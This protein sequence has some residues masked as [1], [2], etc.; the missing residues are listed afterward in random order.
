[1]MCSNYRYQTSDVRVRKIT[2]VIDVTNYNIDADPTSSTFSSFANNAYRQQTK[3]SVNIYVYRARQKS[4][5]LKNL[6]NFSRTIQRYDIKFYTQVI[7]SIIRKCGKFYYI[8][9]I[10]DKITLLLVMAI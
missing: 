2:Q 10:I 4:I 9:Y 6:A 7:H 1:M 5:P 3:R 8:I